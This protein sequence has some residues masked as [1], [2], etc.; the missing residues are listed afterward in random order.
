MAHFSF[1]ARRKAFYMQKLLTI[2]AFA[3]LTVGS[4]FKPIA[5]LDE[6][7]Q[8]LRE[9]NATELSKY[10][11]ESVEI[12]LPGKSNTYSKTQALVIL[13]DFFANNS[14]R[15]FE[16]KHKGDNSGNLFCIGTL[17]TKSGNYRT[18]VFMKAKGGRQLI[19]EISFQSL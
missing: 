10:I 8:S 1:I 6:V 15:N 7:I 13:Q 5:G 19:K 17:I 12:S 3:L 2:L 18:T 4:G 16:V 14:I 9:G 11:D